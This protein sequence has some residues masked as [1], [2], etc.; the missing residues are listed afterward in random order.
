MVSGC[1]VMDVVAHDDVDA[2]NGWVGEVGGI[3][4]YIDEG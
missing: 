1:V 4:N 3:C 2:I